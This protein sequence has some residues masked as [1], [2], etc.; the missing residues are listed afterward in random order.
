MVFYDQQPEEL[1]TIEHSRFVAWLILRTNITIMKPTS[2]DFDQQVDR[3]EEAWNSGEAPDIR[4]YLLQSENED[5][6]AL[7]HELIKIDMEYRW[8]KRSANTSAHD[9]RLV[10]DYVDLLDGY[11]S[12]EGLPIDLI[13]EE[14]RIRRRWGDNPAPISYAERFPK[15]ASR[16][17]KALKDVDRELVL[18]QSFVDKQTTES[19]NESKNESLIPANRHTLQI[20]DQI[21]D[22]RILNELG[23]GAFA[24]VFLAQQVSMQ[25]LVALKVS[26]QKS[27]ESP[28]L[29][30]LEHPN[31]VRV[32]DERS[33]GSMYLMY[34]QYVSGGSLRDA[35]DRHSQ[36]A[37]NE[38]TGQHYL[39]AVSDILRSKGETV[40]QR[41]TT[42]AMT[43][44]SWPFVVAKLGA[45]IADALSHAHQLGV[46]HRD[47]KPENILLTADGQPMLA[48]FNLSFGANV[49]GAEVEKAFGGSFAY[50]SP[51][52]LQVL[53]GESGADSVDDISDLYSLGTVLFELLT[54]KR[55]F[56]PVATRDSYWSTADHLKARENSSSLS[57]SMPFVTNRPPPTTNGNHALNQD[58]AAV[59]SIERSGQGLQQCIRE[60]LAFKKSD[61]PTTT[62]QVARR[63]QIL[64]IPALESLL[65]PQV[66]SWV[67]RAIKHPIA[68]YL[69]F[70][71]IPNAILSPLNIW[72]NK[73]I[74]IDNFD[75]D[76]FHNV[77][78]PA[79]NF[80]LFPAGILLCGWLAFPISTALEK[81]RSEAKLDE[82]TRRRASCRSLSLPFL[83]ASIV[84]GL[85]AGSGIIF[86]GWNQLASGS[87][88]DSMDFLGF[89]LS[90]LLHGL[91]AACLSL[92]FV[93][94]IVL[95]AFYPNLMSR[96]V[97]AEES[98]LLAKMDLQLSWANACLEMTPLFAL[99]VITLSDQIDKLVFVALAFIGFISH[100]VASLLIPRLR[101]TI[102][103]LQLALKS[104]AELMDYREGA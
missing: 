6:E 24:R 102:K 59:F 27:L 72:A 19:S 42:S 12:D 92:V 60:C 3:F 63:L 64:S 94:A 96:D 85:W 98:G 90:Q 41:T 10:E 34:M 73:R 28:V 87:P 93:C 52:H 68:W 36:V 45:R 31:I 4:S 47:I 44:L 32:F 83:V 55:P 89:F 88:L 54:D 9:K 7:L 18:R 97:D 38:R 67:T 76:F 5:F 15:Q 50:M 82:S 22:F 17:D 46:R 40:S 21:D 57:F 91:I 8:R 95:W 11:K 84:L 56:E 13:A 100:L 62:E 2:F 29:S 70:G 25:R 81:I 65:T 77:E 103:W 58:G 104:T 23:Q 51:E 71:I 26:D 61:R 53:M 86:P 35:I 69:L 49:Q 74:A 30:Q 43:R 79:V 99:L 48:D 33:V 1:L 101:S 78:E 20:G 75:Q 66:D 80:A 39:K 14:Y 16:V 37:R